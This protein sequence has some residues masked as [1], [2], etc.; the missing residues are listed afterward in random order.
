MIQ[1]ELKGINKED[2]EFLIENSVKENKTIEYKE[3]LTISSEAEKKEFLFDV[4]SFANA[5]GGDLIFGI[6]EDRETGYPKE[7]VGFEI[8]NVDKLQLQIETLLRDTIS[9]RLTGIQLQVIEIEEEKNVLIIRIPKSWNS[10]H[11]VTFRGTDKFYT[12]SNNGKYKLDIVELRNAFIAS[13]SLKQNILDF[14]NSR[15]SNIISDDGFAPLKNQ[16]KII[17]HLIPFI[18][19]ETGRLFNIEEILKKTDLMQPLGSVTGMDIRYNFDGL[20]CYDNYQVEKQSHS[21][22]QLYKNGIIETVDSWFIQP[23]DKDEKKLYLNPVEEMIWTF[24]N[25][26]PVIYK[27]LKIN[28]PIIALLTMTGVKGF[29]LGVQGYRHFSNSIEIERDTL[30]FP[31]LLIEDWNIKI[32]SLIKPWFDSMWN[33]VGKKESPNYVDDHW[34]MIKY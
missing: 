11:Q 10:P 16:G 30:M 28:T 2:L 19:F 33:A 31:E 23:D 4:S 7:I 14:K 21:Y 8:E 24:M 3:T 27:Y 17:I 6:S 29:Q 20:L 32:D 5:S 13:E 34:Q 18:S 22:L 15:I 12:R 26:V 25:R 9:P 1:K